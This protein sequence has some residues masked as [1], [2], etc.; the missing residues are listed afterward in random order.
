LL[1]ALAIVNKLCR[2]NKLKAQL[3]KTSA[4]QAIKITCLELNFS[5]FYR[6]FDD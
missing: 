2:K 3:C 1:L 5:T 6:I 4:F